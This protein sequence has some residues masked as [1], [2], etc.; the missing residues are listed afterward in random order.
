MLRPVTRKWKEIAKR[1]E[2]GED[3]VDDILNSNKSDEDRL[4][5]CVERWMNCRSTASWKKLGLV[6]RAMGENDLAK[7]AM[8]RG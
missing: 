3:V 2:M 4:Q 8:E 5:D 1:L 7:K 6:L